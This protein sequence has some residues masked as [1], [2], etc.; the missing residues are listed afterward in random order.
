MALASALVAGGVIGVRHAL[1]TDHLA[2]VATMVEGDGDRPG[3]VGASWGIGHSLPIAAIGLAF[4]ALGVHLPESVTRLFEIV[5]GGVLV[6]LGARMLLRAA[7]VELPTL[8]SHEH[9]SR[10]HKHLSVG[11]FSLGADHSHVHGE[12]FA[13]GVLHG[14]AGSG[15]LVIAMVS[16]APAMG[17]AIA[18]LGAF[19]VLTVATMATVSLLWDRS[20]Q[21]GGTRVLRAVAGV[22]GVAVGGMLVLEQVGVVV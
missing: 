8:R 3:I 15:A 17:Q 10:A 21:V 14:F 16:A 13:V 7:D 5:V 2:A 19:T 4:V 22:V 11:G 20:M 12:S 18:F 9:D 1:E 6:L